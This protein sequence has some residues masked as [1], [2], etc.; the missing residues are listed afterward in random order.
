M[1]LYRTGILLRMQNHSIRY[2]LHVKMSDE[3]S[4]LL[5]RAIHAIR[6]DRRISRVTKLINDGIDLNRMFYRDGNSALQRTVILDQYEIF[7]LLLQSGANISTVNTKDGST[8]L[9]SIFTFKKKVSVAKCAMLNVLLSMDFPINKIDNDG[10]TA[11]HEAVR[12][13]SSEDV[14]HLLEH[15]ADLH[16]VNNSLLD[17][18]FMAIRRGSYP[19]ISLLLQCGADINRLNELRET[20]L[21]KFVRIGNSHREIS[22]LLHYGIDYT[23]RNP[24]GHTASELAFVSND[25]DTD[26]FIRDTITQFEEDVPRL[27]G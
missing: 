26:N 14:D 11:L 22:I 25:D 2:T 1:S 4:G 12:N 3:K 15:G 9:H 7:M 27:I 20:M 16:I 5:F 23:I 6:S 13:S 24:W 10:N 21:H 18:L 19:I 8:V 17:S